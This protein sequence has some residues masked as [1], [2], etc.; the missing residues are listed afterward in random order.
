MQD[1]NKPRK[2]TRLTNIYLSLWFFSYC[3]FFIIAGLVLLFSGQIL[4]GLLILAVVY[5]GFLFYKK[6]KKQSRNNL[7]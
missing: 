6:K 5:G 2:F 7:K 3:V 4:P 1:S